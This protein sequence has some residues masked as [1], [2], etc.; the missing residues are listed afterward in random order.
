MRVQFKRNY[1]TYRRGQVVEL[2]DGVARSMLQMG[3]VERVP[4]LE[5]EAATVEPAAEYA[6]APAAKKPRK[7]RVP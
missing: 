6:V 3:I 2:G 4:Q 7:R 1:Q 5:L